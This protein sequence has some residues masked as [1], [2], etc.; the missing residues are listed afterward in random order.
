VQLHIGESIVRLSAHPGMT[1]ALHCAHRLQKIA[2][3][4]RA[5]PPHS[6]ATWKSEDGKKMDQR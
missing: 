4:I 3:A 1:A 6:R 2:L 5:V